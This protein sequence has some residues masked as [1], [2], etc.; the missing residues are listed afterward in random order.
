MEPTKISYSELT[1][2]LLGDSILTMSD[3]LHLADKDDIE[4]IERILRIY[5]F[6]SCNKSLNIKIE[7]IRLLVREGFI[8]TSIIEKLKTE[9]SETAL[10]YVRYF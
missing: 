10:E 1:A 2:V 8:P 9:Y 6:I 3:C 4:T 5:L 7:E